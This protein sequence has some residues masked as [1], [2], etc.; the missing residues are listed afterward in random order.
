[1]VPLNRI[2]EDIL[3]YVNI[4]EKVTRILKYIKWIKHVQFT[5]SFPLWKKQYLR[6]LRIQIKIENITL[7]NNCQIKNH[8]L[9]NFFNKNSK[10]TFIRIALMSFKISKGLWGKIFICNIYF[11]SFLC[12]FIRLY[13]GW[14]KSMNFKPW[15]QNRLGMRRRR[16]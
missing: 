16:L 8:D 7:G 9:R 2:T 10:P 14:S 12:Y 1:M 13:K 5:F 3:K 11:P 15:V 4:I 6:I